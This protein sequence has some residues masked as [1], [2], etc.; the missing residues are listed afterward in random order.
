MWSSWSGHGVRLSLRVRA[1]RLMAR[2]PAAGAQHLLLPRAGGGS[3]TGAWR[4]ASSIC[5]LGTKIRRAHGAVDV[6]EALVVC[7][8]DAFFDAQRSPF[9]G[10]HGVAFGRLGVF[11]TH[12]AVA[13]SKRNP[14][15][16]VAGGLMGAVTQHLIPRAVRRTCAPAQCVDLEPPQH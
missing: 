1:R 11:C 12:I 16:R 14:P 8:H 9:I 10:G 6:G 15:K 4:G 2:P 5:Q 7:P 13:C 3:R